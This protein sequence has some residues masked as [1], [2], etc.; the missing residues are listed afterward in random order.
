M[1][2]QGMSLPYKLL[3]TEAHQLTNFIKP[4]Q[5]LKHRQKHYSPL[6]TL[7]TTMHTFTDRFL[8][9]TCSSRY[10][11]SNCHIN[12]KHIV[13]LPT[14]HFHAI[15][16]TKWLTYGYLQIPTKWVSILSSSTLILFE[17]LISPYRHASCSI[18]AHFPSRV[19]SF[20]IHCSLT[21]L[22]NSA[23]FS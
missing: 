2:V 15:P 21:S 18:R 10:F 8:S 12:H 13:W 11:A 16:L 9:L 1:R 3:F 7:W 22:A 4:S 19:V 6:C 17:Q 5:L 20:A 23:L 14:L